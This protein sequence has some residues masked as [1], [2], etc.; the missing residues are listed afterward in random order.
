M[1]FGVFLC[2]CMVSCPDKLI[3]H[4]NT[5]INLY[6]FSVYKTRTFQVINFK[7]IKKKEKKCSS[8]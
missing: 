1:S 6:Y 4:H 7:T 8:I 3:T 2:S 5:N